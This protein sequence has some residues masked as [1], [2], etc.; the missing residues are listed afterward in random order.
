MFTHSKQAS[1]R[2]AM[3][4]LVTYRPA[5]RALHQ[6]LKI[7]HSSL[8]AKDQNISTVTFEAADVIGL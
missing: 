6:A 8:K 4:Q 3:K 1:Q 2:H 7:L 5:I